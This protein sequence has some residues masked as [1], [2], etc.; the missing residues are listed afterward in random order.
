MNV[1]DRSNK[2]RELEGIF[3][4]KKKDIS[5]LILNN[6][7]FHKDDQWFKE[8]NKMEFNSL[9]LLLRVGWHFA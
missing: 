7:F 2:R 6:I 1:F 4:L 9:L 5:S 8:M 3:V